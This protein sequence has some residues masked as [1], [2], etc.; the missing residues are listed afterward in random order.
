MSDFF[1]VLE[2]SCQGAGLMG[3]I[4]KGLLFSWLGHLQARCWRL[5]CCCLS[6]ICGVALLKGHFPVGRTQ[7]KSMVHG[8]LAGL[9]C[10]PAVPA[11]L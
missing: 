6:M 11:L 2:D 10:L 7:A 4:F 1:K 9:P 3:F 8:A 5:V